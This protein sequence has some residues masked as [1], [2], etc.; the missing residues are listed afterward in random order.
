MRIVG[1]HVRERGVKRRSAASCRP[2]AEP[3]RRRGELR[4]GSVAVARLTILGFVVLGQCPDA[5]VRFW[6]PVAQRGRCPEAHRPWAAVGGVS[7]E[8]VG[9]AT[10]VLGGRRAPLAAERAGPGGIQSLACPSRYRF[11]GP[12]ALFARGCPPPDRF[13]LSKAQA[14]RT[15]RLSSPTFTDECGVLAQPARSFAFRRIAEGGR[16]TR[17]A[18]GCGPQ[19]HTA[20]GIARSVLARAWAPDAVRAWRPR[21]ALAASRWYQRSCGA[22]PPPRASP[23]TGRHRSRAFFIPRKPCIPTVTTSAPSDHE[24]REECQRLSEATR[25]LQP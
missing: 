12:A 11:G 9:H 10:R 20:I 19:P 7:M 13:L 6:N 2:V 21:G 22:L 8:G 15:R 14:Q 23:T 3:H 5:W 4:C 25:P 17:P 1:R 16:P 24:A 18:R